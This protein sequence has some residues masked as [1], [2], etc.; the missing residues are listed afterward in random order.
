W[1]D[2]WLKIACWSLN[3]GLFGMVFINLLPV[4]FLQLKKAFEDGYWSSRAPEFLQQDAVQTLLTWRAVPDTIFL[5]GIVIL[6]I[7]SIRALFHLRKP[8]HQEG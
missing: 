7:F 3:I 6:V 5:A 4:G 8:T 2:K 1:N